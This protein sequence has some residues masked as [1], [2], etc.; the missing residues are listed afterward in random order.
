MQ[1]QQPRSP[2]L[3]F[4]SVNTNEIHAGAVITPRFAVLAL[5]V[6]LHS[7]PGQ[8]GPQK[9]QQQNQKQQRKTTVQSVAEDLADW[10]EQLTISRAKEMCRE[11]TTAKYCVAVIASGGLLDTLAEKKSNGH[12]HRVELS[13]PA[14][15]PGD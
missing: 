9:T 15:E 1:R 4:R 2:D 12:C 6:P 10:R 3:S 11:S 5:K 7:Q 8:T 14:S 13:K